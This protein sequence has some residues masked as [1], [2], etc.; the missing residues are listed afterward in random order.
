M[1]SY[2]KFKTKASIDSLSSIFPEG[3]QMRFLLLMMAFSPVLFSCKF[4]RSQ[5]SVPAGQGPQVAQGRPDLGT[6]S[7]ITLMFDASGSRGTRGY[8][9]HSYSYGD[10]PSSAGASGANGGHAGPGGHGTAGGSI[11]LSLET[12]A[13]YRGQIKIDGWVST[14]GK[15]NRRVVIG[16]QG[17]IVLN[18]NGGNGGDGGTGGRGQ[19]GAT[20]SQGQNADRHNQGTSGGT[21]GTGGRGGNAGQGGNAG[22]GGQNTIRVSDRDTALLMLIEHTESAGVAGRAGQPGSGGNG[23]AG[24]QGGREFEYQVPYEDI[25][26]TY[27]EEKVKVGTKQVDL[28]NGYFEEVDVFET[29]QIRH[30]NKVT[31]YRTETVRGGRDG[32]AGGSLGSGQHNRD[33]LPAGHGSFRIIVDENGVKRQYSS[34]FN[35]V[36]LGF[37][38]ATEDKDGIIEPGETV[39]VTN[40]KVKNTGGMPMPAADTLFYLNDGKWLLA[41]PMHIK[42][43][44]R[45]NPGETTTIQQKLAF[46]VKSF[47]NSSQGERVSVQDTISPLALLSTVNRHFE[48]GT[49][50]NFEITYPIEITRLSS[51]TAV[52]PGETV[53]VTWLVRN[54]S[55]RAY[56]KLSELKR[57]V[58]TQLNVGGEVEVVNGDGVEFENTSSQFLRAIE[59]LGAGEERIIRTYVRV[60]P[61]AETYN[62][63]EIRTALELGSRQNPSALQRIQNRVFEIRIAEKFTGNR[64][65][66]ILLV[67]NS[68]SVREEILAW[69]RLARWLGM[70]IEVWDLSYYGKIALTEALKETN[71]SLAELFKNK[72]IVWLNNRYKDSYSNDRKAIETIAA[73]ELRKTSSKYGIAHYVVGENATESLRDLLLPTNG[74]AVD[75]QK[76]LTNPNTEL[77]RQGLDDNFSKVSVSRR[78]FFG[79][80]RP[81]DQWLAEQ[82]RKLDNNLRTRYPGES[83]L[84]VHHFNP[85]ANKGLF[86]LHGAGHLEVRRLVDREVGAVTGLNVDSNTMHSAQFVFSPENVLGFVLSMDVQEKIRTLSRLILK[87]SLPGVYQSNMTGEEFSYDV[88]ANALVE[89]VLMDLTHEYAMISQSS[90][91][92]EQLRVIANR[93]RLL[94]ARDYAVRN[95]MD[96]D[97]RNAKHLVKLIAGVKTLGWHPWYAFYKFS[98]GH[99]R[100]LR[101]EVAEELTRTTFGPGGA[102]R[103]KAN[104]R[105]SALEQALKGRAVSNQDLTRYTTSDSLFQNQTDRVF[106]A[107]E[108]G[109]IVGDKQ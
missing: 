105:I 89:A 83:F 37:D 39:Y 62:S 56:G 3:F 57:E 66:G 33:G 45:L 97:L 70:K 27:S 12:D 85:E 8:D 36:V 26:V 32:D 7:D 51:P 84:V 6:P 34:R 35:L 50:R 64:D 48:H 86:A 30:E 81:N 23:G 74:S 93:M 101:D 43:S 47:P 61:D 82:A 96:P 44:N 67:P 38:L 73:S 102:M 77:A 2:A 4:K 63:A 109:R 16:N 41:E 104:E 79:F 107:N 90:L 46:K 53:E 91:N 58:A 18:A 15:V 10:A 99:A 95:D 106:D 20:G 88:A 13:V 59:N 75:I 25:E 87:G 1:D 76:L 78:S 22:P 24:G 28:Q 72:M 103:Q 71:S 14:S 17:Y 52:A 98:N 5:N 42:F 31:R 65:A 80:L 69:R 55:N 29:R 100:H 40:I 94:V 21:G 60:K 108:Y 9:G 54:I 49:T 92:R 19:D 68:A 11:D